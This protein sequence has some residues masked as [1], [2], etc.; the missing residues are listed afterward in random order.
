[1]A[2]YVQRV[3]PSYVKVLKCVT[4]LYEEGGGE[5]KYYIGFLDK[6]GMG[7]RLSKLFYTE[8]EAK[9]ALSEGEYKRKVFIKQFDNGLK[10]YYPMD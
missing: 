5:T 3:N 10:L 2:V 1:M 6:L 7:C 8:A 9:H 4:W